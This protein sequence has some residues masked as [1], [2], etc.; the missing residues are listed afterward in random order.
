MHA[1]R[2]IV[3]AHDF[4]EHAEAAL[5]VATELAERIQADLHLLHVVQPPS[6]TYAPG[7]LPIPLSTQHHHI[8]ALRRLAEIAEQF[9]VTP[10]EERVHVVEGTSIA[11]T[12]DEQASAIGA[13]LIVMGTHGRSGLSHLLHGSVAER[14]LRHAPCPVLT[15]PLPAM[16]RYVADHPRVRPEHAFLW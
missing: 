9:A 2:T 6:F 11:E 12:L 3:V 1:I 13:D 4:S 16:A 7:E 14:T 5:G 10:G 8:E 15:V